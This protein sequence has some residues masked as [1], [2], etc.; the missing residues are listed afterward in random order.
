VIAEVLELPLPNIR[1]YTKYGALFDLPEKDLSVYIG[2]YLCYPPVYRIGVVYY[3]TEG[4]HWKYGAYYA[5]SL[6]QVFAIAQ[7]LIQT[8]PE[9]KGLTTHDSTSC[10]E[11]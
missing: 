6:L 10:E 11:V 3:S 9:R 5:D 8:H 7:H 1:G 2:M 4:I